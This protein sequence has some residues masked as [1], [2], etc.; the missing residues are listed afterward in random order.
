MS[1]YV[2]GGKIEMKAET[3]RNLQEIVER[4]KSIIT[5]EDLQSRIK[6]FQDKFTALTVV[7]SSSDLK[8][9]DF[10]RICANSLAKAFDRLVTVID[11]RTE[12]VT[13]FSPFLASQSSEI[14]AF[15]NLVVDELCTRTGFS[16]D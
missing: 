5:E 3:L 6:D 12:L 15:F 1:I 13:K 16:D 9:A 11:T 4:L 7:K 8:N 2:N 14:Q 10:L